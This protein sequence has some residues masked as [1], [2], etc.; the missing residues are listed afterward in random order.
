MFADF[1]G[2][3]IVRSIPESWVTMRDCTF[4][5]NTLLDDGESSGAVVNVYSAT[6]GAKFRLEGCQFLDNTSNKPLLQEFSLG[7]SD[8][9]AP[10]FFSDLTFE[11]ETCSAPGVECEVGSTVPL[12]ELPTQARGGFVL[13]SDEWLK[14]AQQ[15]RSDPVLLKLC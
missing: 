7:G 4:V 11:V 1:G 14:A 15:V 12:G 13:R 2:N 9:S 8:Q 6:Q 5:D 3:S 10:A